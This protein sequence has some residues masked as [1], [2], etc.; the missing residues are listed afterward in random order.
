MTTAIAP[1]NQKVVS[2]SEWLRAQ[3]DFLA[4]E[5]E[6]TRLSDELARERRELPW[7]RV[8]KEYVFTAP[9]GKLSL[10]DLFGGRSQLATYHF[11]FGPDWEEGCPGCSYVMDH[12]NGAV[13]HLAARDV[14]L[15]VVSRA[16]LDKIMAFKRRMGWRFPWVSSGDSDFNRDFAVSFTK[17]EL[18]GGAKEYNFGTTAPHGEENPGLSLFY[19]DPS[20][21]VFHTYSSYGRGLEALLPTYA[22]LDR[23]PKGRDKAN[24]PRPMSWVR[25]HDKYEQKLIGVSS[26]CHDNQS[27]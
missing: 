15:I 10:A 24:L 4:K 17:E 13:E 6:L 9:Q 11:M 27:H 23:A 3:R 2:Q 5:K 22:V 20:G 18:A 1:S 16:P 25:H 8:E 14:A 12:M 19:K 26:C 7:T 21:A